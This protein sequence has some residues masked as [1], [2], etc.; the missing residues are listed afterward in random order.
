MDPGDRNDPHRRRAPALVPRVMIGAAFGAV[1]VAFLL[2]PIHL[3]VHLH[4]HVN[5]NEGGILN[6]NVI[7]LDTE[8]VF[9]AAATIGRAIGKVIE[10]VK[11]LR[12]V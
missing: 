2:R 8:A 9:V 6:E 1:L 3:S 10:F 4:N 12:R 7:K 11:G 5:I